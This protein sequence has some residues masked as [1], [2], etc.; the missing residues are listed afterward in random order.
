MGDGSIWDA[1]AAGS[2]PVIPT[3]RE[4]SNPGF[5]FNASFA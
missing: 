2:N 4:E 5:S 3:Y 1:V